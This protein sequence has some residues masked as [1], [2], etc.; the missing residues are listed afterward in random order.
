[1]NIPDSFL[2]RILNGI[3]ST[4]HFSNWPSPCG[5]SQPQDFPRYPS[6]FIMNSCSEV[7]PILM[8]LHDDWRRQTDRYW[9]PYLVSGFERQTEFQ[10]HKSCEQHHFLNCLETIS[11]HSDIT[12]G[13]QPLS[14]AGSTIYDPQ[15]TPVKSVK[16]IIWSIWSFLGP[17][18]VQLFRFFSVIV[19]QVI[20]RLLREVQSA[21]RLG[22]DAGSR[23]SYVS[24]LAVVQ[25]VQILL[26][27]P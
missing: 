22:A 21:K 1:M 16:L 15:V 27:N 4:S 12:N 13:C 26:L 5:S 6:D 9:C 11:G 19:G 8:I 18:R 10:L 3:I 14:D 2:R 7:Q 17:D 24:P 20:Q 25:V 23:L